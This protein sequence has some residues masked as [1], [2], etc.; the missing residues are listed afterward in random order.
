MSEHN[1]RKLVAVAG[2]TEGMHRCTCTSARSILCWCFLTCLA[3]GSLAAG[4]A[5][6]QTTSAPETIFIDDSTDTMSVSQSGDTRLI[7]TTAC[8]NGESF[9]CVLTAPSGMTLQSTSF[10]NVF[11]TE[12]G[13]LNISD[14]IEVAA[15]IPS[16]SQTI[17]V[18]SDTD[19]ST[20]GACTNLAVQRC[21]PETGD[22]QTVDT[23]T[24]T[25]GT[26]TITDTLE[27]RSDLETPTV[28]EPA[29]LLL[30]GT[31]LLSIAGA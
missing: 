3:L 15:V 5:R 30:L 4:S 9:S 25:D 12:P 21:I 6:A 13:T 17:H 8:V 26:N 27:V 23:I 20:F 1:V 28:P 29:S 2:R 14:F 10:D 7:I 11:L 31:G 22:F 19:P 18:E 16:T 24:W